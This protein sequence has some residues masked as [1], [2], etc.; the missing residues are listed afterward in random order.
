[1]LDRILRF[2]F[3]SATASGWVPGTLFRGRKWPGDEADLSHPSS[4]EVK[5]QWS[6]AFVAWTGTAS[7]VGNRE[8]F[9]SPKRSFEALTFVY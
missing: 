9:L 1:L 7:P 3:A 5:N 8:Q 4:A 6:Y 2:I